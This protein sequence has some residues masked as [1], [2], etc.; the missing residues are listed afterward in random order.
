MRPLTGSDGTWFRDAEAIAGQGGRSDDQGSPLAD[1]V[2][3]E[4]FLPADGLS[5]YSGIALAPNG[6]LYAATNLTGT[7][8]EY[9]T[10]GKRVRM[11]LDP[12][13]FAGLPVATAAIHDLTP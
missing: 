6:N 3:R 10:D 8:A 13:K 2:Q 9:T 11:I 1:A 12:G 4:V 7:I 5:T